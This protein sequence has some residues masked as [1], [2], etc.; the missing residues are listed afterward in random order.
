MK[1][2][3]TLL[4]SLFIF[5]LVINSHADKVTGRVV[6]EDTNPVESVSVE[7]VNKNMSTTTDDTGYFEFNII[8]P[9]IN[10]SI[11]GRVHNITLNNG[12]LSFKVLDEQY[13]SVELYNVNGRVVSKVVNR[14]LSKGKY[15]FPLFNSKLS[16][17]IY[18]INLR[19][20]NNA[21]T[22]KTSNMANNYL[23]VFQNVTLTS[24]Q[25]LKDQK[26]IVDT[27]IAT[28]DGYYFLAFPIESYNDDYTLTL[29]KVVSGRMV[30]IISVDWEGEDLTS[31][32][33]TSFKNF[34]AAYPEVPLLQ[35]LNAT[36]YTKTDANDTDVTT[37]I[38]FFSNLCQ[39]LSFH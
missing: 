7:L 24:E 36:Y 13:V 2:F 5:A 30:I 16:H 37:K 18:L 32:N 17:A 35:F 15:S 14:V 6:D 38:K 21:Y 22:F 33:L 23:S 10:N 31:A 4:L 19:V 20:G 26:A 1:S 9:I 3:K 11:T 39:S 29:K 28:K 27:L 34:R 8:T 12:N 25:A